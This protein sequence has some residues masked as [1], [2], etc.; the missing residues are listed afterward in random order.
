MEQVFSPI[1][2]LGPGLLGG[3]IAK[4]VQQRMPGCELRLWAR[5]KE[6]LALAEQLGITRHTGTDIAEIVRGARLII[7]ATPIS[8]FPRLVESMLPALEPHTLITDVG[9]VKEIVHSTIGRQLTQAGHFFIGSHPMA[10]AEKQG[11]E[12]ARADLLQG[13]MVALT[14]PHGVPAVLLEQLAAFW[15]ALGGRTCVMSP[16]V[17][18]DTVARISHMPHLLA[19]LCAR[20]AAAEPQDLLRMLA[21]TGFRDTTRVSSGPA[22]MWADILR[23]NAPAIR[24]AIR[25]CLADLQRVDDMLAQEN[26]PGLSAW[27]EQAK[28]TREDILRRDP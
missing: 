22:P 26:T 3:S 17:H 16:L 6:P 23:S 19:A 13:A 25:D 11:L 14:N 20:N 28:E 27:L 4:A 18:D 7:L 8:T 10:G 24:A 21:A 15:R 9:S 5:R 2:V 12:H 1:A